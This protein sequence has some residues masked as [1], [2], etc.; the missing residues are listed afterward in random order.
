MQKWISEERA[1]HKLP[2]FIYFDT[3]LALAS[4]LTYIHREIDGFVAYHRD[5]KPSNILLFPGDDGGVIWKYCD[6]GTSNLKPVNHTGTA[7]KV[8]SQYWAPTEFFEEHTDEK[9]LT[10]GRAHDVFSL[11]CVF[12]CLTTLLHTDLYGFSEF[13]TRREKADKKNKNPELHGAFHRTLPTVHQWIA[14][15]RTKCNEKR[16]HEVLSLILDML[17]SIEQRIYAWEV[18]IDLFILEQSADDS[19]SAV[20]RLR[21]IIHPS[22]G[23]NAKTKHNPYTRAKKK[24]KKENKY[25]LKRSDEFFNVMEEHG[26]RSYSHQSST[27]THSRTSRQPIH[28]N[29]LPLPDG[30]ELCGG[31]SLYQSIS[32]AFSKSDIVA[33]YG[34]AG[35]G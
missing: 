4:G 18:E 30:D 25:K 31:Q 11:G 22:R 2:G 16:S 33:L 27:G 10:H 3:M 9:G 19:T 32:D 13:E 35:I 8:T 14:D 15:L 12:L 1:E 26:W 29:L 28:T 17:K 7:S 34:V 23:Y 21:R 5:I 6:F 24:V 20:E